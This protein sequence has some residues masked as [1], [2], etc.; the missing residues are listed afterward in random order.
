MGQKINRLT[1][2]KVKKEAKPGWYSDGLGLYLQVSPSGTKSWVYRYQKSGKERRHGLGAFPTV[3][4]EQARK[5]ANE[6][7]LLR[8]EGLDP[9]DRKKEVKQE[10]DLK[11]NSNKTFKE[12]SLA[13]IDAH[14]SAWKNAK[15]ESQW[16][17]TLETYVYPVM[18]DTHVQHVDVEIVLKVL[19]PIWHTK[20]ETASRIRQR[21]ENI[22]DW[23]TVRNYRKGEN[24]ARWRGHLDKTLPKRTKVQKVVHFA[25]M[26]YSDLPQFFKQLRGID[27]ITAKALAFTILTA[28]RSNESRYASPD[29]INLDTK[30]WIIP[31]ERMKADREHRV[32][33]SEE[34][35]KIIQE[36]DG[37]S[38]NQFIFPGLREGKPISDSSLLNLLKSYYPKLTV[39]GFRSTFR[40]WCAEMTSHPREVAEAALAHTLKDKTEAAYQRG[41]L[42]KKRQKLMK[43]WTSY[44]LGK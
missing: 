15:H 23:A 41:D 24:P 5:A 28:T 43:E 11:S 22:L 19:E 29:E 32:P 35:L 14:K 44:C 25:A 21:I 42:F 4:L 8:N 20:T 37:I 36:L 1:A 31:D 7:R 9:I 40:D 6:C 33:L 39:H 16:R 12:C 30:E 10:R 17:N 2:L 27:T 13:Y 26:S 3:T 34:A 38:T 18:G